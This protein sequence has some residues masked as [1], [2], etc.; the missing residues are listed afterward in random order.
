MAANGARN[1]PLTVAGAVTASGLSPPCISLLIPKGNHRRN[2]A[3]DGKPASMRLSTFSQLVRLGERMSRVLYF[4]DDSNHLL[5]RGATVRL[6]SGEVCTISFSRNRVL[7]RKSRHGFWGL[8]LFRENN[9]HRIAETSMA[10]DA[11]F[12]DTLLPPGL[13]EPNLKAFTNAVLQC[14][15]CAEV[16]VT[17]NEAVATGVNRGL[18]I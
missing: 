17:L 7:V 12:P 16:V 13:T 10:L 11:L 14:S 15:N 18:I 2:C 3:R 9:L 8:I 4:A 5:G 6:D 1:S